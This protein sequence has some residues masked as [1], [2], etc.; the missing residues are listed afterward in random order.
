[1]SSFRVC[2]EGALRKMQRADS[3]IGEIIKDLGLSEGVA[4]AR[5][6]SNWT[7]LFSPP[8]VNHMSAVALRDSELLLNVDSPEWLQ[9]LSYYRSEILKRLDPFGVRQV[10]FRLGRVWTKLPMDGTGK[11]PKRRQ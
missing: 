8:I 7:E 11:V 10:R 5:I 6:K 2:A 9:Q 1:M 4:L 3:L